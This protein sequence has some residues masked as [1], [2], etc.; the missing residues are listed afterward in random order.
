VVSGARHA[1][2][3]ILFA[4]NLPGRHRLRLPQ[5]CLVAFMKRRLFFFAANKKGA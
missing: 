3:S 5:A 4:D 1:G 2:G